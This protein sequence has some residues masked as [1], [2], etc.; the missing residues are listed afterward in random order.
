MFQFGIGGLFGVPNG[1]NLATPSYPQRFGVIQ[2]VNVDMDKKL[3]EL[4]G[5]DQYPNDIAPSDAS[6]KGK[7]AFG[8]IDIDIFNALFYADTITTGIKVIVEGEENDVPAATTYTVTVDGAA[9]F[10][11]D[12][13]VQYGSTGNPLVR[14][15]SGSEALGKYSVV[16]A[17]AGKGTYTFA[18]ADANAKVLVSYV[19]TDTAGRTLA[20]NNHVQGYGPT[21]EL[22]L[23]QPYQGRNGM[24]L[25]S[26]RCA[27]MS[28][29]MKRDGYLISDFEFQAFANAAGKVY[30]W[31]QEK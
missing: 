6:I 7:A 24:H 12:L 23:N 10:S 8:K 11:S 13:G 18:A 2:D 5:Q 27:K 28:A 30:E 25:W 3:V 4:R 15:A 16:E 29:P 31:F 1:G 9:T 20:V 26:V 17:G 21:F 19:T 22:W 14:V